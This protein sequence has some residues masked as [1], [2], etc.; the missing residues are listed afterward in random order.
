MS[1][2]LARAGRQRC[3]CRRVAGMRSPDSL[4]TYD[5]ACVYS[6]ARDLWS[7]CGGVVRLRT[8]AAGADI[9]SADAE[10][11]DEARVVVDTDGSGLNG[12]ASHGAVG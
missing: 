8:A 7:T 2:P 12:M 5:R 1:R 6:F 10:R 3:L 11:M 9:G 4:V